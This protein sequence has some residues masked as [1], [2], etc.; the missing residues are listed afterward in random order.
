MLMLIDLD[1]EDGPQQRWMGWKNLANMVLLPHFTEKGW[2]VVDAPKGVY[3]KLTKSVEDALGQRGLE[4]LPIEEKPLE[5]E[6]EEP[7]FI[8]Q[9]Q[10]N[11]EV[12]EALLETHENWVKNTVP[13]G[14]QPMQSY[15]LR[16][17]RNGN[18]LHMHNDRINSHIISSILHVAHQYEDDKEPW[19][20]EIEGLDGVV[21]AV[22]L[23]PGQMLLYESAK[24]SHGR[25]QRFR[26]RYYTS[27]FNHYRP[28]DWSLTEV[29]VVVYIPNHYFD[30]QWDRETFLRERRGVYGFT[31]ARLE[32][33]WG[34]VYP[35][36]KNRAVVGTAF[37]GDWWN[38]RVVHDPDVDAGE[39]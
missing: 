9:S 15:G 20:I 10:T 5:I 19:P 38:S 16:L 24:C 39:L 1:S 2:D 32:K 3:E 34:D 37:H 18:L 33:I 7:R 31:R 28:L 8:H 25:P 27:L 12:S 11:L 14:L 35:S 13:A 23:K 17:Y 4:G 6:G 21:H 26:G 30:P 22:N 29:D 36:R